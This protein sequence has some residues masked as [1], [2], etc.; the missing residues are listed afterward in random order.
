MGELNI[1]ADTVMKK[2]DRLNPSKSP[3]P[4]AIHPRVLKE[5][6]AVI[7]VPIASIIRNGNIA[8]NGG[9]DLSSPPSSLPLPHGVPVPHPAS[10]I[11]TLTTLDYTRALALD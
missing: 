7:S 8:R 2:L 4:D 5:L 11:L 3:G 1:T 10:H 9:R 6:S